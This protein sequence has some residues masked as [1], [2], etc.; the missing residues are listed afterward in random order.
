[1]S[2]LFGIKGAFLSILPVSCSCYTS[3]MQP[4]RN[5]T[6]QQPDSQPSEAPYATVNGESASITPVVTMTP[7]PAPIDTPSNDSVEEPTTASDSQVGPDEQPVYWQATEYI[8]REKNGLWFVA[9]VF[10]T[11]GLMAV[12]TF[13]IQSWTFAI[14]IPVMATALLTYT[15]RPPRLI[16]YTLSRK[17]LHVNDHLY[18]FAEFKAF[19]VIRD[20]GEYSIMLVPIKR[21]RPGVSVY[22][23]EEVG[24]ALVDMLGAR[25]P[26]RDL[27]LDV[28]DK[29]IR[30]LRI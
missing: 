16:N 2:F 11:L 5:D 8:Q 28:V 1:M 19:G 7:D 24:E 3:L 14:L 13:L 30:K 25:L 20:A 12:A 4:N 23:P 18:S 6:W 21:F 27:H 9:F 10:I 26:M 29:I 17:G 22:F 15:H